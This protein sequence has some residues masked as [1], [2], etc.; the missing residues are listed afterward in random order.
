VNVLNTATLNGILEALERAEADANVRLIRLDAVGKAFSAGVDV[1]DHVGDL[2]APMMS[3]FTRLFET[4]DSIT[5]PTVS[6]VQGAAL[7]GGCELVLGTDLCFASER[8]SFGQPEIRL[9]VFAPPASVLLPRLVGERRALWMLLSG[10]TIPAVEAERIGLVNAVFPKDN[11]E[12]EVGARLERLL[13]LSGSALLHA[14]Q[15]VR[16]ARG[17]PVS[18]ALRSVERL[19]MNE[20]MQTSDANEGLAAFMEKRNPTWT[21]S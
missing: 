15:A 3:T 19:Y 17:L 5:K 4:M 8:A 20:L 6:V 18:N 10:E 2:I 12:E 14:K 1:A 13:E 7:G 9:A 21:H 16:A 11:L